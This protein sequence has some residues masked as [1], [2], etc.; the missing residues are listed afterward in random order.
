MNL[1]YFKTDNL[2][3]AGEKFFTSIDI[4]LNYTTTQP[5]DK[6]EL[7]RNFYKPNSPAF[8]AISEMYFFGLINDESLSKS[9]K[10]ISF[11]EA[12]SDKYK[13]MGAMGVELEWN[14]S[15]HPSRTQLAEIVRAL[16]RRSIDK[17]IVVLFR[18]TINNDTYISLATTE[19]TNYIAK[20]KNLVGEKIGKLVMLKDIFV[21]DPNAAHLRILQELAVWKGEQKQLIEFYTLEQLFDYWR[22]VFDIEELNK[23][24]YREIA[25]WYFWAVENVT[26]PTDHYET[27][28]NYKDK[29]PEEWQTEANQ[30][31]IIRLLTRFIF[32]WFIKEK[33]LV[34]EKLFNKQYLDKNV[35]NYSDKQNSTYYKAI[36]QNLFF[37][38]LNTEMKSENR[39]FSTKSNQSFLVL[40]YRYKNYF[41]NPQQ[42]IEDLFLNIPFLNG[43]LFENL[44]YEREKDKTNPIRMDWF[45][46]PNPNYKHYRENTLTVP[47]FLFFEKETKIDLNNVYDTKSKTYTVQGLINILNKYKFTVEENTPLEVD[48]ALDPELLGKVFENLLAYYN[49]ETGKTARKNTGSFYTPREIVDYMVDESLK[50]Y[51]ST[52][53]K[54]NKDNDFENNMERLFDIASSENPFEN[55]TSKKIVEAI[56]NIKI[57]DPACGS[58][59]FP[60]GVLHRLVFV[61]K[62]LD[63]DNK[64]WKQ[65]QRQKAIEE[66]E[67]AYDIDIAKEREFRLKEISDVFEQNTSDYGRKLYLI[68]NSIY[69]IDIQ[70]IAIQISKLRFFLSLIIEQYENKDAENRG[71]KSLPNLETKFVAANTLIGINANLTLVKS[72]IEKDEQQLKE[73]RQKHFTAKNREQKRQIQK[74]DKTIRLKILETLKRTGFDPTTKISLPNSLMPNGCLV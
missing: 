42:N 57:L 16:N 52:T 7:L 70:P 54:K 66:T 23:R 20:Q 74:D 17:P 28:P 35:L 30:I 9:G 25:N 41:K 60:M 39:S 14:N 34:S 49:P 24:F 5:I 2:F 21:A 8:E 73:I 50:A 40:K 6:K 19:R 37:A 53:L 62:K 15:R 43:G 18:Y 63:A 22:K 58:G 69:G 71:Y 48:V 11:E 26:F 12:I 64:L 65:I 29:T 72:L 38:T 56:D 67:K 31:A 51:F 59:A 44:D 27:L 4:P 47:D 32:V 46:D 10:R 61:L 3:V 13:G 45:S 36:L 68:Q 1:T 55:D 33:H